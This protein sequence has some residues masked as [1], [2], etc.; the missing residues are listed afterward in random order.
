MQQYIENFH[1]HGGEVLAPMILAIIVYLLWGMYVD[2][3]TPR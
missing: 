1:A 3:R 2:S